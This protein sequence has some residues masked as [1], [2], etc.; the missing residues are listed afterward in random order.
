MDV[1][2]RA[3]LD[4]WLVCTSFGLANAGYFVDLCIRLGGSTGPSEQV[5][6]F[7]DTHTV[8]GD[9]SLIAEVWR[10]RGNNVPLPQIIPPRH[11]FP[12]VLPLYGVGMLVPLFIRPA[13]SWSASDA[14]GTFRFESAEKSSRTMAPPRGVE[15]LEHLLKR[16]ERS[17]EGYDARV[18]PLRWRTGF[19]ISIG[20]PVH[21]EAI[22]GD[23]LQVP[24]LIALLRE[25]CATQFN[26]DSPSRM[27]FGDHPVFSSGT[28]GADDRFGPIAN[29]DKK[30]SAF[31]REVGVGAHAVLTVGQQDW[32]ERNGGKHL[33]LSVRITTAN[34]LTDLLAHPEIRP[35]LEALTGPP[36]PTEVDSLLTQIRKLNRSVWFRDASSI[37][38]WILPHV[39]TPPYRW[40]TL[41]H[42]GLNL[43]HRGE[44]IEAE[45]YL[46]EL[47]EMILTRPTLL[48]IDERA[49]AAAAIV[50]LLFDKAEAE[51][52]L[53]L[54]DAI[55]PDLQLCSVTTRVRVY[56]AYCQLFRFVGR[57]DEA[58]EAGEEA[59]RLA[60][61]GF[62]SEAGRD[63]NYLVHALLRRA[64]DQ[65][66]G[67]E[68]DLDRAKLL[69]LDSRKIWAPRDDFNARA[70]HLGFCQH[71]E[72]ELARLSGEP[73]T[74]AT[75]PAWAGDWGHPRLFVLFSAARNGANP[76]LMREH[77]VD[78]LCRMAHAL[79]RHPLFRLFDCVYAMY[80]SHMRRQDITPHLANLRQWFAAE[81]ENGAPGWQEWFDPIFQSRENLPEGA[82]VER[83]CDRVPYH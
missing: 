41:M 1:F 44:Y 55:R 23:S 25:I 47:Q 80:A 45:K 32:L 57:H 2:E 77:C 51:R 34:S 43:L 37:V 83:L 78:E 15:G 71:Y 21:F 66:D 24:L 6:R 64:A 52:G 36:H 75:E 39:S 46:A 7:I 5:L 76:A 70:A 59:F 68:N 63:L 35:A 56:G 8:I 50:D 10:S 30:L 9:P 62:A 19:A 22:E 82:W 48:G 4:D 69:L 28:L 54:L 79:S 49:T 58:V 14:F 17:W 42:A 12:V 38:N 16:I 3:I 81:A 67:A 33:L 74:P 65:P 72:A 61:I 13:P 27:P 26:L 29:L 40:E 20:C 60:Q 53:A 73:Y 11:V 18:L 31:I